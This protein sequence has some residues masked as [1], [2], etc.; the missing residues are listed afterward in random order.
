MTFGENVCNVIHVNTDITSHRRQNHPMK[1]ILPIVVGIALGL[2]FTACGGVDKAGTA[3]QA[4]NDLADILAEEG[5]TMDQASRDCVYDVVKSQS[6]ETIKA[7][8]DENLA[9]TEVADPELVAAVTAQIQECLLPLL[10]ALTAT[11]V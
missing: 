7:L 9:A 10:T 2:G 3:E 11:T 5:V 1:R 6:D 8:S 4:V